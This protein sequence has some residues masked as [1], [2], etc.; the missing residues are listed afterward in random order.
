MV[1]WRL[2]SN[3]RV[4]GLDEEVPE[5]QLCVTLSAVVFPVDNS[6]TW[7]KRLEY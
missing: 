6:A 5:L 4:S 1:V 3:I 2:Q 7:T